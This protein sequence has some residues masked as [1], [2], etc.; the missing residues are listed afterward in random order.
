M[1]Q[2]LPHMGRLLVL[3]FCSLALFSCK[4]K[5]VKQSADRHQAAG[6]VKGYVVQAEKAMTYTEIMGTLQA[7]ERVEIAARINGQIIGLPVI[8]GSK[9]GKG[10][11]LVTISAGEISDQL[12]QT[13]AQL[14][15]AE[16]NLERERNLLKKNASTPETVKTLEDTH[17]I[18]LAAV[19]EARTMLDYTTISAPFSGTVTRK[20][21]HIGDLAAPG[22]PLLEIE[23]EKQLQVIANI[24]ESMI[25]K[26]KGGDDIAVTVPAAGF[27]AA[28]KV[29]EI[30][31]A[32]D[33]QSRTVPIKLALPSDPS[34]RSGQFARLLFPAGDDLKIS[35]PQSA[36]LPFGQMERVFLVQDGK[37]RL[38]LV[39]TGAADKGMV[40]I[41]A[42]LGPGDVVVTEGN[43]GLIDG[44]ALTVTQ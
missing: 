38:R 16:R 31:P 44:Q 34:L 26:I 37:A 7:A 24:P 21:V 6:A 41:L 40:E 9:V 4:E 27:S 2:S 10:D 23:A 32:A 12:Q 39:R 1:Q 17:R 18:A 43:N 11:L 28:G 36:I 20:N 15:Q 22:K 29:E 30:S 33:P 8:P 5:E 13:R 42:G 35:I 19:Q 3:L 14:A 25:L